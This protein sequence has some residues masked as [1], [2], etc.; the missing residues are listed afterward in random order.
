MATAIPNRTSNEEVQARAKMATFIDSV[1][2]TI[3]TSD[4]DKD[5]PQKAETP[6]ASAGRSAED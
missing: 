5:I 6:T 3:Q 2:E 4:R 1:I